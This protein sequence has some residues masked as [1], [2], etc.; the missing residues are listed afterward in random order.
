MERKHYCHF[1]EVQTLLWY[2]IFHC[3]CLL[4][5]LHAEELAG[6]VVML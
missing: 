4:I 1:A 3:L 2:L 6:V 5:P